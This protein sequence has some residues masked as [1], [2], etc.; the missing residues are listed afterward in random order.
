MENAE[1][2][3]PKSIQ[4]ATA[5]IRRLLPNVASSQYGGYVQADRIDEVPRLMQKLNY[6][7]HLRDAKDW[8]LADKE[9]NTLG[10]RQKGFM[11]LCNLE[12][13]RL[14]LF[15]SNGCNSFTS[16]QD[17]VWE[18]PFLNGKLKINSQHP[19]QGLGK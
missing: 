1:V 7:K 3:S 12:Y 10:K 13:V 11:M 9:L 17:L 5:Q 19:Y 6:E 14:T 4:T 18:P 8:V 15:T 2:E 16:S